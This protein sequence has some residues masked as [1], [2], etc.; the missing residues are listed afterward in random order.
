MLSRQECSWLA[1]MST[2]ACVV[3]AVVVVVVVVVAD[4]NVARVIDDRR[5]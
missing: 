5:S 2:S 4:E 3:V 1:Q